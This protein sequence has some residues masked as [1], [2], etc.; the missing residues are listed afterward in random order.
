MRHGEL[1]FHKYRLD[2]VMA[3]VESKM[4]GQIDGLPEKQ[5]LG[6][7]PGE[8]AAF[9]AEEYRLDLPQIH[10]DQ[11][12]VDRVESKRD[13]SRHPD[14]FIRDCG[15]PFYVP[16]TEFKYFVPF[17]GDGGIFRCQGNQLSLNP[18][19]AEI[20]DYEL[21][22]SFLREDDNAAEVKAEFDRQLS[23]VKEFLS[24]IVALGEEFNR[25]LQGKALTR[26][27]ARRERLT[28]SVEAVSALGYPM[29]RRPDAAKTYAVPEVKRKVTP[30]MPKATEPKP[31]EPTLPDAE[32]EHILTVITNMVA[33]MERSPA[34]FRTM[35][36]EDLRQHFLVQL[37]GQYEGQ[38]TG[39]TFNFE[40]KTDILIR[41]WGKNIFIAECKFW[42]GPRI[43]NDAID[44]LLGYTTWHDTKTALLMFNRNRG[45]SGVLAKIPELVRARSDCV[46]D[47][48]QSGATR[49]RFI[50]RRPDDPDRE[51][52]LTVLVFEVPAGE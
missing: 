14:R 18:P 49:F 31:L 50:L 47:V 8:L 1:L 48:E 45:L 17:D 23:Q 37:N 16:V 20:R 52:T 32:Y 34:A 13:V 46:R 40:G 2:G 25:S 27:D 21:V 15:R 51:V 42:D 44:Q 41:A 28:K 10:E 3:Q 26:I 11:I 7:N 19:R 39:E 36:E 33:V 22:F 24:G 29:R 12:S 35:K 30:V 9:F 43:F 4:H 5:I 6:T 38:A